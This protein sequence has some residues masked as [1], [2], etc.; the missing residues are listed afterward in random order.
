MNK[1]ALTGFSQDGPHVGVLIHFPKISTP[2]F[3][4]YI[5]SREPV[6]VIQPTNADSPAATIATVAPRPGSGEVVSI[7]SQVS[8]S[9]TNAEA[10]PPKP[11]NRCN[12]FWHTSH[13]NFNCHY[14]S[15]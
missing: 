14:V 15:N 9:A 6:N 2:P 4:L 13:F 11:L 3:S 8:E 7:H 5:A 1:S 10:A 12:H